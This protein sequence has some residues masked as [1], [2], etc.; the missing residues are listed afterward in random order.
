MPR[1]CADHETKLDEPELTR[2]PSSSQVPLYD[3]WISPVFRATGRRLA[4]LHTFKRV[5]TIEADKTYPNRL[6]VINSS[7]NGSPY[8]VTQSS[9][10]SVPPASVSNS[11]NVICPGPTNPLRRPIADSNTGAVVR[12]NGQSYNKTIVTSGSSYTKVETYSKWVRFP[13]S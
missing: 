1:K 11:G 8:N 2:L 6:L 7:A 13:L 12:W 3:V 5:F 10:V 9:Q 4:N